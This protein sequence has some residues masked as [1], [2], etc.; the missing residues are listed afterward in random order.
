[1]KDVDLPK[2][3]R[4]DSLRMIGNG[5]ALAETSNEQGAHAVPKTI[6][7]LDVSHPEHPH[8]IQSFIGVTA[9]AV[10]FDNNLLFFANSEGLW[11]LSQHWAQPPVYPCGSSSALIPNPNCE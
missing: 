2:D 8:V 10:S 9:V 1:M 6:N 3:I 5:L 4:V 7:V 11:I